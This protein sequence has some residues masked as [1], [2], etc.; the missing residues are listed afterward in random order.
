M[1]RVP[2]CSQP[3]TTL[4]SLQV[5]TMGSEPQ[6]GGISSS[7]FAFGYFQSV[8][9]DEVALLPLHRRPAALQGRR[10]R[11][12]AAAGDAE[13]LL[14]VGACRPGGGSAG[15]G[16]AGPWERGA[17]RECRA[18][19]VCAWQHAMPRC[20]LCVCN[21]GRATV[22]A[23][24]AVGGAA[25]QRSTACTRVSRACTAGRAQRRARGSCGLRQ[26]W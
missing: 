15:R 3:A 9:L 10:Q 14:D 23:A 20:A 25:P 1:H 4:S 5:G 8:F 19:F 16:A 6:G 2:R 26:C 11:P 18:S 17:S 7:E 12:A 22:A 13:P 21:V 24:F